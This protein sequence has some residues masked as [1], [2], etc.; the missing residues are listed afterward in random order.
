MSHVPRVIHGV[1]QWYEIAGLHEERPQV[2]AWLLVAGKRVWSHVVCRDVT[3]AV[4]EML[5]RWM[6]VRTDR[7][8]L[9][10]VERVGPAEEDDAEIGVVEDGRRVVA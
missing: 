5:L 3:N 10:A 7:L 6:S 8:A 2:I 9:D 4:G 1:V